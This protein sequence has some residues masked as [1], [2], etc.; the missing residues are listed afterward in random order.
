MGERIRDLVIVGGGT[1]GWMVAAAMADHFRGSGPRITLVESS[2]IGTIG[3]GEAT[4]PTIRRFYQSLGLR[5][6]DVLKATHGTVKLGIRFDGWTGDGGGFIHPFGL[7]GQ[8]LRGIPFHHYWLRARTAGLGG[9][10]GDYSLAV[11]LAKAGRF[12]LPSANPPSTLSVFDWALHFDAGLFAGLMRQVAEQRGVRRIDARIEQVQ[13]RGEDGHITGLLLDDG[14]VV[15]GDLF[16]DCSGFQGLL[17]EGAMQAGYQ[18]WGQW[19][20]C[21][22]ALAAQGPALSPPPPFTR[23]TAQQAGWRWTIPLQHRTGHGYVYSSRHID[24]AAAEA[25]L[26][27]AIGA[28]PTVGPR[29]IAFTPG[30]RT[31]AWKGNCVSIGLSSGFLEPLE[32]TSIAL[33]ETGI[34]KLKQLFPDR[35]MDPTLAAEFNDW[36]RREMERVR[37]FIILHYWLNRRGEAFWQDCRAVDLPDSLAHKVDLFRRR[38]HL[39]RYRWEMFHPDSWLAIFAGFGFLPERYDPALDGMDVASLDRALAGMRQAIATAVADC[40][41]HEEFI[42]HYARVAAPTLSTST[43]GNAR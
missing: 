13:Q 6:L 29:R 24:D 28:K 10:F 17:I 40:P 38:G 16:V 11:A 23:V 41:S 14:R 25:E 4:I 18:D 42:E 15:T 32:S 5:D 20:L 34:E 22:R 21:D 33:I 39:V 27:A 35:D 37:D 2:T 7:H 30:R 1:A 9:A 8:D 12:T 19:L 43:A 3:V 36:S 31:Q 26:L